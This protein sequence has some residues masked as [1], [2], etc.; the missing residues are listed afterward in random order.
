VRAKLAQNART[1]TGTIDTLAMIGSHAPDSGYDVQLEDGMIDGLGHSEGL[2]TAD[3]LLT[4]DLPGKS[5]EL[6]R[7]KLVVRE[8]PSTYHG[9][10]QSTLNVLVGSYVRSHQLGA[11]FGQDT[12]FKIRSDP[13]TV[14]APDLAFVQRDRVAQIARR[15]YAELAPDLV[16]EILSPDDRPGEV[17]TKVGEWLDAGVSLVWVIDPDRRTAIVYRSDVSVTTIA[18]SGDLAGESV[19]PGFSCRLTELFE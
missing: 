10:V 12:G 16:A 8:P 5:T 15:G 4:L 2:M 1:T 6:V 19:L 3:E 9:R 13:D 14:R 17:L 11:V 18:A 7:G